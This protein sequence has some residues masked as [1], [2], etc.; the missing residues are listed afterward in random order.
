MEIPFSY[1]RQG[2]VKYFTVGRRLDKI[3]AQIQVTE[4]GTKV[5]LIPQAVVRHLLRSF[6]DSL[7][8]LAVASQVR[9]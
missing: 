5:I 1:R 2:S 3:Q 4:I 9:Y 8:F 6:E 7:L